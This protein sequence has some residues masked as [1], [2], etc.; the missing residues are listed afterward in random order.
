MQAS[1]LCYSSAKPEVPPIIHGFAG[2]PFLDALWRLTHHGDSIVKPTKGASMQKLLPALVAEAIG[3]FALSFIGILAIEQFGHIP[4]PVGSLGL[5]GIA[6]AHGLILS[7]MISAFGAT[8]G[9]HF[10]PAVTLGLASAGKINGGR[11]VAYIAAQ[12]IGGLLAGLAVAVIFGKA[13]PIIVDGGTPD[14]QL[15]TQKLPVISMYG[16]FLAE[17]IATFFLV[18]AVWGTA[19]D[20]RA[21]KIGGFGIGLTVA[22][23]IL[24]I[25]PLTGAAMNPARTFGP[26]LAA[27]LVGHPFNW[28]NHW[29]YWAGPLIGGIAASLLYK[30]LIYPKEG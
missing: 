29:I 21:P 17:A 7:I 10:N 5:V 25:G 22:A 6:L 24:A 12:C 13:G 15:D 16:A 27:T 3:V 30:T 18:T 1:E 11:A 9:G 28:S 20:P 14:I 8:S 2:L 26:A 19:V 4:G 23:D